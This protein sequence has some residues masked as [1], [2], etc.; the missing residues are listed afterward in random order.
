L[1]AYK[2]KAENFK[3]R[4]DAAELA[5][6][7]AARSEALSK[8]VHYFLCIRNLCVLVRRS[9]TDA[10]NSQAELTAEKAALEAQLRT[11]GQKLRDMAARLDDEGR[12]SASIDILQKRLAEEL[13]D[14]REQH[15]KDLAERDF[16][17]DQTRKKYQGNVITVLMN[18]N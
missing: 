17:V 4:L 11:A 6:A 14:E 10:E 12:E 7:K 5:S 3:N 2:A 15:L 1:E 13:E 8:F 16:A 18:C 9:L